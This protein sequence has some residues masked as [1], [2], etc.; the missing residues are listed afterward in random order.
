MLRDHFLTLVLYSLYVAL[1][2]AALNHRGKRGFFVSVA[3]TT[4]WMVLGA[5]AFAYLMYWTGS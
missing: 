3:K 4:G 2:F 1:F 5:L